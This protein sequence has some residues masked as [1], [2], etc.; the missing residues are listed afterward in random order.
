[1]ARKLR[2]QYEGAL[3]PLIDRGNYRRDLFGTD[4]ADRA[5]EGG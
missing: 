1:M 2:I 3:Y 5:F 4:G